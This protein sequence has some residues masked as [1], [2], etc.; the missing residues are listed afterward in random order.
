MLTRTKGMNVMKVQLYAD[1]TCPFSYMGKRRLDQ[2]IEQS[3]E[4]IEFE[5]KAFQLTPDASTEKSMPTVDLLAKKFG[6][7]R[8]ET[9]ETTKGLRA[10]AAEMGL[11]YNYD[12]MKAPNTK[13]PHQLTKWAATFGKSQEA[14]EGFFRAIFTEGKDL[15]LEQDLLSV[16]EAI[17]LD[18][19][20]AK[21]V[22]AN[23]EYADA[24]DQDRMEA[25][26]D[27]IRSVP[28]FVID[29]KYMITGVQPIELFLQTFA[30]AK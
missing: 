17:G 13:K 19:D 3:E 6:R 23:G 15:N 24:V 18:T 11:Q 1:F 8:E 27:G 16:V 25:G 14:T 26:H 4:A 2:A 10:Q 22:L 29:D 20:R 30:K 21:Q 7:T 28:V 5:L 9:L 12:T